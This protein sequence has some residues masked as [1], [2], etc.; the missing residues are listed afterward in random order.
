MK[1]QAIANIII[2]L[3]FEIN[4]DEHYQ[5]NDIEI[6]EC[7]QKDNQ[8]FWIKDNCIVY[9]V[10]LEKCKS[11]TEDYGFNIDSIFIVEM[12]NENSIDRT[13]LKNELNKWIS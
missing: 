8:E 9:N 7:L 2:D 12:L 1:K 10:V 3:K 6:G 11:M 13:N 4:N 5:L